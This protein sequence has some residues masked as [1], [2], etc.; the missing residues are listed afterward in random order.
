M[1][2]NVEAPIK[3]L[4]QRARLRSGPYKGGLLWVK[5]QPPEKKRTRLTRIR[6]PIITATAARKSSI[7]HDTNIWPDTETDSSECYAVAAKKVELLP[8]FADAVEW[9]IWVEWLESYQDQE[10][11]RDCV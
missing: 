9:V 1:R 10:A 7:V 6:G 11:K 8:V 3:P 5:N 4:W 2:T